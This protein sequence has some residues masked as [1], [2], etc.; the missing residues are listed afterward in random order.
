MEALFFRSQRDSLIT[1]GFGGCLHHESDSRED[2]FCWLSGLGAWG[3]SVWWFGPWNEKTAPSHCLGPVNTLPLTF[4]SASPY[5][6]TPFICTF[7]EFSFYKFFFT[8]HITYLI[9]HN[10]PPMK[11]EQSTPKRRH[12]KFRRKGIAQKKAYDVQNRAKVWNQNT[13]LLW[14]GNCKTHSTIRKTTHQH[15]SDLAAYKDGINRVFENVG[16]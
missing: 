15:S 10:Y 11:M 4:M 16:I 14:G 13:P 3:A 6:C 7:F 9:L 8:K 1:L 5:N 12:I 2:L